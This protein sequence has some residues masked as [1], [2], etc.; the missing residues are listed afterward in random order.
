ML[1]RHEIEEE[2]KCK[3]VYVKLTIRKVKF[4]FD[5]RSDILIINEETWNKTGEPLLKKIDM[6]ARGVSGKKLN[7]KGVFT[8]KISF[9]GKMLKSK[10][11][12]LQKVSNLFR[13]N[14]IVL[15]DLWNLPINSFC[16]KIDVPPPST[17]RGRKFNEGK[18][19][20]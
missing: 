3:F 5:T 11:L 16:N 4:Q 9:I 19:V 15:F 12:V 7:F 1:S 6:V 20:S 14:W 10:V 17:N 13:M 2:Q 8:C 18:K